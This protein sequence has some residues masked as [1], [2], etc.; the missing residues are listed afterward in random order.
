MTG[1]YVYQRKAREELADHGDHLV[2]DVFAVRAPDKQRRLF[3]PRLVGILVREVAEMIERLAQRAEGDAE[4]ARLA[5]L[6][7][8]EILEEKLSDGKF[9]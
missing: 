5:P 4:L 3:E 7:R 2:G 1:F 9:L 8:V 6:G